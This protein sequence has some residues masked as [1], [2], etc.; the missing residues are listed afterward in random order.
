MKTAKIITVLLVVIVAAVILT[1][2]PAYAG[3]NGW[4]VGLGILGGFI[5]GD[6]LLSPHDR[7]IVNP[8]IKLEPTY[9][10]PVMYYPNPPPAYYQPPVYYQPQPVWIPNH[11]E[12]RP[13]T[14]CQ[15]PNY[16]YPVYVPTLIYGHWEYR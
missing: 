16:C 12:N 2:A 15:G 14:V 1:P 5:L 8:I 9:P 13:V 4:A 10:P 6:I 3:G 11:Y 7:I